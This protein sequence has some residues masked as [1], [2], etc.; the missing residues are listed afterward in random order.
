MPAE[1]TF[2]NFNNYVQKFSNLPLTPQEK[3]EYG[4]LGAIPEIR[5]MW[6]P[7]SYTEE[8]LRRGEQEYLRAY[9]IQVHRRTNYAIDQAQ[10]R[11]AFM[12]FDNLM[13]I[14]IAPEEAKPENNRFLEMTGIAP[15]PF[16]YRNGT[17]LISTVIASLK[18]A[19]AKIRHLEIDSGRSEHHF[20][21][22]AV[23]DIFVHGYGYDYLIPF[24]GIEKL[25]ITNIGRW[26]ASR[27]PH[28][29]IFS[30][31]RP[32][33]KLLETSP[34]LK[35]LTLGLHKSWRNMCDINMMIPAT[36]KIETLRSLTLHWFIMTEKNLFQILDSHRLTLRT[37]N[38][39]NIGISLG[40]WSSLAET[41]RVRLMLTD[42]NL[43]SL[44]V[45]HYFPGPNNTVTFFARLQ[46]V[47]FAF[48]RDQDL[49]GSLDDYITRKIDY[50]PMTRATDTGYQVEQDDWLQGTAAK[51]GW[52]PPIPFLCQCN[53]HMQIPEL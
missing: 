2:A 16:W 43:S 44:A 8:F 15:H 9:H 19:K 11:D 24:A 28:P 50:N 34:L 47:C 7:P 40:T 1:L 49:A 45:Q 27:S 18:F 39:H 22:E 32:V 25:C 51:E 17:Y 36:L 48:H 31:L 46:R 33:A 4:I 6:S 20:W 3:S 30:N 29:S 23:F 14:T 13:H 21:D 52:A 26:N 37:L 35:E 5:Q 53:K 10:L 42:A 38:L 12:N 41:I